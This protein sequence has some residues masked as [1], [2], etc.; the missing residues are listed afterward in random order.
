[1]TEQ[2]TLLDTPAGRKDSSRQ[3]LEATLLDASR[4]RKLQRL[5]G[6]LGA[7]IAAALREEEALLAQKV[8]LPVT[9]WETACSQYHGL[10]VQSTKTMYGP[11]TNWEIYS[12]H[13]SKPATPFEPPCHLLGISFGYGLRITNQPSAARW[14]H[15][16]DRSVYVPERE[17]YWL[18]DT[19][20][21]DAAVRVVED[22]AAALEI[23]RTQRAKR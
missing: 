8:Q 2:L 21:F 22:R 19:A 15:T 16:I 13:C 1:M 3:Q 7:S 6:A 20:A 4:L 17:V 5:G 23:V 9:E 18:T 11:R 14:V 10:F 12:R